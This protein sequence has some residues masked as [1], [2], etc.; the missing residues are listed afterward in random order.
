MDSA[1][2]IGDKIRR[3]RLLKGMSQEQLAL[4]SGMNVSYL[5]QIERGTKRKPEKFIKKEHR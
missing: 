5:G 2:T 4:N 3:M 1:H